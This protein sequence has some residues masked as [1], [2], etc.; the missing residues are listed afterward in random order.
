[1]VTVGFD[2]HKRY[3]TT[4]ALDPAGAV[5]SEQRRLDPSLEALGVCLAA[6]P[7]PL[8]IA[9]EATLYWHWLERRLTALGYRVVVAH[10]YQVKLIWQARTK[11]GSDLCPEARR[12]RA[13]EPVAGDL[14]SRRS[15]PC[16]PPAAP[17]TR[18]SR[19]AAH[20]D[21]EPDSRLP[22]GGEPS[23]SR[24]GSL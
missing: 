15:H 23:L 6:L 9:L 5:L 11:D 18:V 8:T 17:R 12:T 4:C 3:I 1:M 14:E 22:D 24:A 13:G 10:P 2:L 16:P 20:G 7:Q 21:A 19:Q